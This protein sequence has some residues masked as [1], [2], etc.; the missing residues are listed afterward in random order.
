MAK[1]GATLKSVEMLA[2]GVTTVNDMFVCLPGRSGPITPGVVEA[3]DQ[4]GLRGQ[5]SF[6][7]Q[8]AWGAV[9]LTE[10]FDEHEA[11][12]AAA[13]LTRR[14][15][16]RLGIATVLLQ[17]RE[18]FRRSIECSHREGWAI[19]THFH[20]VR[21]EV[22]SSRIANGKTVIEHAA[23]AGLLDL[24]VLG[25]HCVWVSDNDVRLL[26][27]HGVSVA[28]NPVANM[29]LA[30]GICPVRQLRREGIHVGLGTDGP[31][32]NDSQDMLQVVKIAALVQ[33]L[34]S[35][36][37]TAMS[38]PEVLEMATIEGARA[39]G[40]S[41]EV[42]SLERGKQA[43]LVLLSGNSPALANI[44]DPYQA[45]VYCA[46]GRDVSDVW[47]AGERILRAGRPVNIDT[48]ALFRAAREQASF[49]VKK[50]GLSLSVMHR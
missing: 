8:D 38:A 50:S 6:G 14:I 27:R 42:G 3:L 18:L 31:A 34:A 41:T 33:K 47:V 36:D 40:I 12:A 4:V 17:S 46:G 43:D 23:Q 37:A 9:A 39:L 7:A 24:P 28:Y 11:L 30:S 26:A 5:V 44:H 22:T 20:E 2:S 32:S 1:V 16:F 19:H 10:I 15:Q 49:L 48:D 25:A 45:V 35:L 13:A 29:I 21:E